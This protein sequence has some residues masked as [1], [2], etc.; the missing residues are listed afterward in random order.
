M[1]LISDEMLMAYADGELGGNDR[2]DVEAY[3]AQSPEGAGRLV[4]F[5]ATGRG[6]AD[7]LPQSLFEPVPAHLLS[8]VKSLPAAPAEPTMSDN[9]IAFN[10]PVRP[11]VPISRRNWSLAAAAC[12][13]LV[14]VGAGSFW[15]KTSV[16]ADQNFALKQPASGDAVAGTELASA[17]D[18]TLSG[19]A[20]ARS[21]AGVAA[22]IKPVFTFATASN[23]F[24]RQYEIT[25]SA[26]AAISGVACRSAD[27]QWQ[28][29]S[30]VAFVPGQNND[31][32]IITAGKA[33]VAEVEAIVDHL[34]NG[35]VFDRAQE[36][37][38]MKDGWT[39]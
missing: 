28:I 38:L 31:G 32:Q 27:G 6:L 35:N 33:G 22:M 13:T 15:Y 1:S 2:A 16:S 12:L 7:I 34:I 39:K 21:I 8:F 36:T 26:T 18:S 19:D 20:A 14:A 5:S 25:R 9:V 37:S 30:H 4:I 10:R 17:L 11:P 29:K 23:Q 24:C 3:L